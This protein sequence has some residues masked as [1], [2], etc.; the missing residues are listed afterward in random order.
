MVYCI[1]QFKQQTGNMTLNLHVFKGIIEQAEVLFHN[2]V[3]KSRL[4]VETRN[5]TILVVWVVQFL[6]IF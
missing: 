1:L 6:I 3:K 5:D 4:S 2:S